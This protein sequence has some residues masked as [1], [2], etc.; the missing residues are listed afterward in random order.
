M[1]NNIHD[2][3]KFTIEQHNL[4]LPFDIMIKILGPITFLLTQFIEHGY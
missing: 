3:I 4:Y 2:N 1:L